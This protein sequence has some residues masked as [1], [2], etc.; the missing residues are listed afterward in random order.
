MIKAKLFILELEIELLWTDMTYYRD[1][2]KNGKPAT[3]V[4]DGKITLC[5]A[6]QKGTN[7]I[8]PWLTTESED[9]TWEEVDKMEK[10]KI[11]FYD[12]GFDYPP[13]RTYA[14]SD[15][16]LVFFKETFITDGEKPMQTTIT[17][18]AAIQ[19]FGADHIKLWN[20]SWVPPSED[21][22]YQPEEKKGDPTFIE[23]HFENANGEK[24]EQEK[25]KIDDVIHLIIKTENAEGEKITIDLD[26]DDLDY[27]HN[28]KVLK[29]DVLNG[30]SVTGTI[31]KIKLTA[32][33]QEN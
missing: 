26:D 2:K 24:I 3:D 13:T 11:C 23:Y 7:T 28:G 21:A 29:N 30:V 4:T 9:D 15:A 22:P 17:I 19:N 10:G 18:S 8:L 25:I 16:H 1:I 5:F 32:V 31:T 6:T 12:N 33:A 20:V 14:F 27:K